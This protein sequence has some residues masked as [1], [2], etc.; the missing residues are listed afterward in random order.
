MPYL[1][2][3][4]IIVEYFCGN[5]NITV[6]WHSMSAWLLIPDQPQH[7]NWPSIIYSSLNLGVLLN[8][9]CNDS[10]NDMV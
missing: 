10:A 7:A 2:I 3:T 8:G 9:H 6:C 4:I 1:H 5:F